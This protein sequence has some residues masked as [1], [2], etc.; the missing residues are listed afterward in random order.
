MQQGGVKYYKYKKIYLVVIGSIIQAD[1]VLFEG[2]AEAKGKAN[3]PN[4][5]QKIIE[6]KYPLSRHL[7]V[8]ETLIMNNCKRA[9]AIWVH[10]A[11][12]V[13]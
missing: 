4:I 2:R 8:Y 10:L 5:T 6:C 1:G 7:E 12:C 3:D 9:V 13:L 11:T